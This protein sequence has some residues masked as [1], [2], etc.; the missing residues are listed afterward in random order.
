MDPG[1]FLGGVESLVERRR[2]HGNEPD[3]DSGVSAA[4]VGG[5]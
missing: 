3:S 1:N 2:R 4:P 5:Y